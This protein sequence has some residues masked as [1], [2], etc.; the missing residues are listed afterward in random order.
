MTTK[1][2]A[3]PATWCTL[4]RQTGPTRPRP[5]SPADSV[6]KC[7]VPASHATLVSEQQSLPQ[8]PL[9][10][11]APTLPPLGAADLRFHP[12]AS[13]TLIAL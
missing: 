7:K 10:R 13:S 5:C 2:R 9:P 4:L 11:P 8:A 6:Y 1:Q 12:L 3:L